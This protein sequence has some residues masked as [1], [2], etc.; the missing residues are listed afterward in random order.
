MANRLDKELLFRKLVPSRSKAQEL[1]KNN[2]VLCN[3]KIVNKAYLEDKI[4][5]CIKR[6]S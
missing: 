3:G 2:L 6:W 4:K 1:I 5:I